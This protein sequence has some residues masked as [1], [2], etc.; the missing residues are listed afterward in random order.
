MSNGAAPLATT[1]WVTGAVAVV[2]N[3]PSWIAPRHLKGETVVHPD[4]GSALAPGRLPSFGPA[5]PSVRPPESMP[6][7]AMPPAA[8]AA[9]PEPQAPA[10]PDLREEN[11]TLRTQLADLGV[12]LARLRGDVLRA[13]EGQLVV[14]ACAIAEGVVRREL[15]TDPELIVSWA[16]DGIAL[17]AAKETVVVAIAPDLKEAMTPGRWETLEAD[18]ARVEV[19]PSLPRSG[20]EIR[21][22]ASS[23]DASLE[24]RLEAVV[25][26]LGAES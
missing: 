14:L 18:G 6:A 8:A 13:S 23:V 25:R 4:Y 1:S 3:R 17:L 7:P 12:A 9:A 10:Y 26:E 22:G 11:A 2:G 19:D 21:V 20:C 5:R 24:G 15:A 16:R